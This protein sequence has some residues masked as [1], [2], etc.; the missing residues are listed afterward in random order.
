MKSSE[1]CKRLNKKTIKKR[2]RFVGNFP[3]KK[4]GKRLE[5]KK[6][7]EALGSRTHKQLKK[8]KSNGK[9]KSFFSCFTL[10]FLSCFLKVL[11]IA[12]NNKKAYILD[13][14]LLR[15]CRWRKVKKKKKKKITPPCL[16]SESLQVC[17]RCGEEKKKEKKKKTELPWQK[18]PPYDY[19][20]SNTWQL[21][22]RVVKKRQTIA[23]YGK[24]KKTNTDMQK[25]YAKKKYIK[26]AR[27]FKTNV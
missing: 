3:S 12:L 1:Q 4:K 14:N 23:S 11:E 7:V 26:W 18:P 16:P 8:K 15:K 27:Y 17:R 6:A 9:K 5:K 10:S 25:Q 21:P 20:L 2:K 24:K 19:G 13:T 22:T